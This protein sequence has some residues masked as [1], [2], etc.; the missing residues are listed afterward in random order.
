[1]KLPL[2]SVTLLTLSKNS[3]TNIRYDIRLSLEQQVLREH[4]ISNFTI[5]PQIFKSS[6]FFNELA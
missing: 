3:L 2:I 4:E 6:K 5:Q 1:M